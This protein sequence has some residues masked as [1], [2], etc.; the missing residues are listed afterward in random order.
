MG[1]Y[2]F[3]PRPNDRG[4]WHCMGKRYA[5]QFNY[6]LKMVN[7][8]FVLEQTVAAIILEQVVMVYA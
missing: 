1:F 3:D 8:I 7:I 6:V 2:G 4:C 5:L